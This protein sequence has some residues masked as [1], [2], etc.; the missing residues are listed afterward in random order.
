MF[1]TREIRDELR[2]C[3]LKVP[4]RSAKHKPGAVVTK[5]MFLENER[6]GSDAHLV[7]STE[8]AGKKIYIR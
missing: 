4:C 6:R 1:S 2:A 3:T 8:T 7:Y 5:A